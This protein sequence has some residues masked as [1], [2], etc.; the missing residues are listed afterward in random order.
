M[1]KIEKNGNFRGFFNVFAFG[2][3]I[4]QVQGRARAVSLASDLAK[5]N[6]QTHFVSHANKMIEVTK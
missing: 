6:K 4:Q 1:I 5:L 3:L 2:K